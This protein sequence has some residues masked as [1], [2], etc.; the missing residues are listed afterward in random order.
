MSTKRI[1]VVGDVHG[2][3][4]LLH[5]YQKR[6]SE[7][8]CCL[9]V[10]D[11][12]TVRSEDDLEELTGPDKYNVVR[13]FPA[14]WD[15]ETTLPVPTWF[16]GG[17]HEVWS[18]L[19]QFD[20]GQENDPEVTD[21]LNYLGR[22][23][24]RNVQGLTIAFLS[25]VYGPSSYDDPSGDRLRWAIGKDWQKSKRTGHFR[26][27]EVENL[28]EQASD[29]DVDV[30][31]THEWPET[32]EFDREGL[33]P[34]LLGYGV[35]P[36]TELNRLIEPTVHVAGHI[37]RAVDA[38]LEGNRFLGVGKVGEEYDN[39]RVVLELDSTSDEVEVKAH[40]EA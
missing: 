31:V 12:E 6:N 5:Q 16:I 7:V 15:G 20:P 14:Y 8:D 32:T 23:G 29:R 40:D 26:H 4:D 17:N 30:L 24:I 21:N 9:Q 39:D 25:G 35:E 3:F 19:H 2:E 38:T 13:E 36:V 1:L 18:L 33:D 37:H 10:G 22:V 27:D 11:I 34:D 28:L